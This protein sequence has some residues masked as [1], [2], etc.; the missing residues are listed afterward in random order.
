MS[1]LF[2]PKPGGEAG[3][4]F[5][6]PDLEVCSQGRQGHSVRLWVVHVGISQWSI[7]LSRA[8]CFQSSILH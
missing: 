7:S 1:R 5:H 3:L 2:V 6:G 4:L 8:S